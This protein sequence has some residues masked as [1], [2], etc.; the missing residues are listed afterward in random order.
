MKNQ[1]VLLLVSLGFI[2]CS[3][4]SYSQNKTID[5]LQ[6]ILKTEKKEDSNK[7]NTLNALSLNFSQK[8]D[9]ASAMQSA[10]SALSLAQKIHF[11]KGEAEAYYQI[12]GV[13]E[14]LGIYPE[15]FKNYFIALKAQEKV[16]GK[17]D[18]AKSYSSIS[19]ANYDEGSFGDALKYQYAA[20]KLFE[21]I[22]DKKRIARS[23][24][25]LGIIY[26]AQGSD[27]V[28]LENYKSS[29]KFSSNSGDK[30]AEAQTLTSIGR[31]Y[32]NMGD[33]NKAN[34]EVFAALKI[35]EQLGD[36]APIWGL[37]FCYST[38]GGNYEALGEA[39]AENGKKTEASMYYSESLK[40]YFESLKKW[41]KIGS[42]ITIGQLYNDIS[43]VYVK[44]KEFPT[45]TIYLQNALQILSKTEDKVSL[46]FSY[47]LLANLDSIEGNYKAALENYKL[48]VIYQDS[49]FN[50][51]NSQKSLQAKMQYD[52][53]KKEAVAKAEQDKKDAEAKRA[54][55]TQYF[56]IISLGILIL[57][58]LIITFIQ[59]RNNKQKQKANLLLQQQKQKIET[60][61]SELK[62]T[63]SQL[64]QSEKMASLGELTAGIAHEIQNPLNFVNNFSEVNK[65]L[66]EEMN[67]EIDKGNLNEVKAIAKDVIDN[68]QKINHHGKRAD[69]IVKG[70]LEHSRSSSG[71]KELTDINSLADE[72]LRLAY[73]GLRAKDKSFNALMKTDYDESI[74]S[75]NIIPQ[76]IGRVIL[77]LIT[78]AFYAV[79]EMKK[80]KPEG[81]EPTVSVSTKKQN[82]KVLIS[83]KDNGNGIPQKVMDKIFQPFFTTKPTGQGTGLGLSLSYDII[84]AHG[85]EIKVDT[86]ENE[87]TIFTIN[88]PANLS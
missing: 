76:D 36:T 62:S 85:G 13:Y 38:L 32:S 24:Q 18:V 88:L 77:N 56:V 61:L 16:G 7:V 81:F 25:I 66:L 10:L 29:L 49:I 55:D 26:S 70:M 34:E 22:E 11:K 86:K 15:A 33:G 74:G 19:I 27:S 73:H 57:A 82:D 50:E 83:V 5:S 69:A 4:N 80:S 20:L 44:L 30:A 67:G 31:S 54:R 35:Y 39:A 51:E 43:E 46:E 75:I 58:V 6:K 9:S 72:Y 71:I 2:L 68:E 63:Q 12:G 64:I 84:K 59:Y 48:Q 52:F 41:K 28:A 8:R 53:D 65:E 1:A 79:T 60:T 23:Y 47:T 14:F 78:N 37:P 45:A 3:A 42:Q 21:E 40:Y 87:G 17:K